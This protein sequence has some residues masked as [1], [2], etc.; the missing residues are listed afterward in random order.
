MPHSTTG[1]RKLFVCSALVASTREMKVRRKITDIFI[2]WYIIWLCVCLCLALQLKI[3]Y[4]FCAAASSAF[5]YIMA[6][7]S[8]AEKK[9]RTRESE[10][11][12]AKGRILRAQIFIGNNKKFSFSVRKWRIQQRRWGE[13]MSGAGRDSKT[14]F[15]HIFNFLFRRR[16]MAARKERKKVIR[17]YQIYGV[18]NFMLAPFGWWKARGAGSKSGSKSLGIFLCSTTNLVFLFCKSR[19][20]E[21]E[22]EA[23]ISSH[24]TWLRNGIS[25]LFLANTECF[26]S[27]PRRAPSRV[28]F[29]MQHF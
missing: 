22:K 21:S 27:E 29:P 13:A 18:Y 24:T 4:I 12:E 17:K 20:V 16:V 1:W 26:S 7:T 28:R 25:L 19:Q 10:R 14:T 23:C 3:Y 6:E 15:L 11:A 9:N 2:A 8:I 5:L